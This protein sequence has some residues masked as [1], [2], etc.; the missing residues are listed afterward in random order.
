MSARDHPGDPYFGEVG[1]FLGRSYLRYSFTKG[2]DQEV[3]F[4][5]DVL[6]LRRG[7]RVLDVGCG[8][9]RHAVAL[10]HAGLAVTGVDVSSRFLEIAAEAARAA[11]VS[12]SFFEV[13]ARRMPFD[14]EFDAVVS[15]CQGAFG[16]MGGDDSLVLRRMAEA[17]KPG[18]TLVVTAF[19]SLFEAAH[20]RPEASFDADAGVVHEKTTIKDETG[21]EKEVELWTGVYTPRELRLL[22]IGV[23]LIPEHV[24]SVEPG[25]FARRPPD[26]EHAEFMLVARKP[27]A[28]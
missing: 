23:G 3:A 17:L 7:Q 18:G 9:G 2:T 13:D 21:A 20:R 28:R 15:I 5:L 6:Q 10:A 27:P 11:G 12:A 16:L 24:W 25:D 22:A 19:S 1:D 4:L 14:D 8:P 26:L